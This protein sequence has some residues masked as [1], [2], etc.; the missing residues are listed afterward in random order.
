MLQEPPTLTPG[1]KD[2]VAALHSKG[3][4]V[5]LV[6]GGFRVMIEPVAEQLGI[7]KANIFANTIHFAAGSGEYTGFD[8]QEFT[9]RA[10]GKARAAKHIKAL[11]GAETLAMIGDGATDLEARQPG[12]ADLFV[13][14]GGI[15]RRD[16]V[17]RQADWAVFDFDELTQA[18]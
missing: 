7:P 18:L 1:V 17:L 12:G 14:F 13:G 10:G 3:K 8:D 2:L 4:E 6:S 5:F 15:A 9:S 16:N 11:T